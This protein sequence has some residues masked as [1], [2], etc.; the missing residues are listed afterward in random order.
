MV[1]KLKSTF[2][3]KEGEE[4]YQAFHRY[5]EYGGYL[6]QGR[7]RMVVAPGRE[8][9]KQ[10]Y[11]DDPKENPDYGLFREAI[12]LDGTY[13]LQSARQLFISKRVLIPVP[14]QLKLPEDPTGDSKE[15]DNYKFSGEFGSGEE[16]V[17]STVAPSEGENR[18]IMQMAAILDV[19]AYEHNWR[20]LHAFHYHV[21][22]YGVPEESDYT[23]GPTRVLENLDFGS[24]SSQTYMAPPEP[25]KIKIDSR[26]GEVDYFEREAGIALL[27]DG[28]ILIY[29]GYGSEIAMVGGSIR[30][31][32]PG[33]VQLTPGRQLVALSGNDLILRAHESVDITAGNKDLR[34]KAEKNLHMLGGNDGSGGVLIES[35]ARS[36]NFDFDNKIGEDVSMSGITLKCKGPITQLAGEI[37]LRTGKGDLNNGKIVIDSGRGSSGVEIFGS[38]INNYASSTVAFYLGPQDT[39]SNV[40]TPYY[41]SRNAAYI[42]ATTQIKGTTAI[43]GSLVVDGS[44]AAR[45]FG[46][47]INPFVGKLDAA[48]LQKASNQVQKTDADLKKAGKKLHEAIFTKD[49]YKTK[50]PGDN[51]T[52]EKIA[53]SLRDDNEQAQYNSQTFTLAESRWQ[54]MVRLGLATGGSNWS[55]PTV[56]YQGNDQLPWP[57]KKK[58]EDEDTLL[59][60][61]ELTLFDASNGVDKD[62]TDDAYQDPQLAGETGDTPANAYKIIS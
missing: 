59:Q 61:E 16:H 53:F 29:D 40:S 12:G 31:S 24:L 48:V 8:E 13:L 15:E 35:K 36:R 6:G 5:R 60:L 4:G 49:L 32:C 52:I 25:K 1:K 10:L 2:D 23:K 7:L 3:E 33:D 58:W 22:D 18:H 41:F 34:L 20:P 37:Y 14:K 21:L 43:D 51:A 19:M 46:G 57:G 17:I 30:M 38:T 50:Q 54:T 27:P 45:A 11:T 26:Y 39:N 42:G 56:S 62:R 9:G 44:V 47:V 28:G 55:E